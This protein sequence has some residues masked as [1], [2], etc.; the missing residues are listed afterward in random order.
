MTSVEE[1][2]GR[3]ESLTSGPTL[4]LAAQIDDFPEVR[5]AF[6]IPN[7]HLWL[8]GNGR[9]SA[10]LDDGGALELVGSLYVKENGKPK[11]VLEFHRHIRLGPSCAEHKWLKVEPWCRGVGISS[12][13]LLRSFDLYSD[14]G[15]G[16]VELEAQMET[17]KWH[18]ARV[19]FDFQTPADL[20]SMRKWAREAITALDLDGVAALDAFTSAT[21]F[22]R[23]TARREVSLEELALA[24]PRRRG[25]AKMAAEKNCLGM[26]TPIALGRALMLT[27]PS[28]NGYLDLEGPEYAQFKA[29][30]DA[31][32]EEAERLLAPS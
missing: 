1:L 27:G 9:C 13:F 28:W 20:E 17:G 4:D 25:Q 6:T 5:R 23:M 10:S 12:A 32:A 30:A 19:G 26:D 31:K 11:G 15:V 24:V 3:I 7:T 22:A 21:Q 18:W 2:L 16:R 14:L 29:Y 8:A